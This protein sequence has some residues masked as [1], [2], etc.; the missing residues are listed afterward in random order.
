MSA[1][2]PTVKL[3]GLSRALRSRSALAKRTKFLSDSIFGEVRRPTTAES[4]RLVTMF[5]RRPYED[6]KEIVEVRAKRSILYWDAD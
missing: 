5:S 1:T 3:A 6:R 4:L 2:G